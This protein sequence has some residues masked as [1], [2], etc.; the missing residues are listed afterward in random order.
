M[1]SFGSYAVGALA[2]VASLVVTWIGADR[3]RRRLLPGWI[4]APA[5][6]ATAIVSIS[7]LICLAEL[8][9]SFGLFEGVPFVAGLIVTGIAMRLAIA[10][11]SAERAEL[12]RP[13]AQ[14][15]NRWITIIGLALAAVAVAHF[16]IGTRIGYSGGMTGFDSTWYHGPYATHFVQSA[17]TWQIHFIAPQYLSWFYPQNSEILHGL[18]ILA[19][20]RDLI[21]PGLNLVWFAGCLGAAWCIGRP[22]GVAPISLAGVAVALD[23][24]VLADQAG[25]ARN[26]IVAIFFL[27]AA[28]AIAINAW[29]ARAGRKPV[30]GQEPAAGKPEADG[31][32]DRA[33]PGRQPGLPSGALIVVGLAIGL[34]AGTKVNYLAPAGVFAIGIAVIALSGLRLRSF[35][36]VAL[37]AFATAGYWYLRNTAHSGSP[38]PWFHGLGP[39]TLPGPDQPI[40]GRQQAGVLKYVADPSVWWHWFRPGLSDALSWAW[41]LLAL[42][43]VA[44]IWLCWRRPAG[45][46][47][48]LL[49]VVVVATAGA[50]LVAPASAEGPPGSPVGFES[51]LRYLIPALAIALALLPAT[52][53]MS[54]DPR[55]LL[56]LTGAL[57]VAFPLVD[58]SGDGWSLSYL[59]GAILVGVLVAGGAFWLARLELDRFPRPAVAGVLAVCGI[60]ALLG[61]QMI[62]RSY[63][64]NR[65]AKPTFAAP[66]LNQA[67]RWARDISGAR[68][69]TSATRQYPLMGLDL[70]NRVDYIGVRRPGAGFVDAPNCRTWRRLIN[71]GGYEFVVASGDRV[72]PGRVT[73]PPQA[74][75]TDGDP[76]ARLILLRSPT[77]VYRITGPLSLRGCRAPA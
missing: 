2:L 9:G 66:G 19:F 69:A 58:A 77:A 76:H 13:D 38:L 64:E 57:V 54:R 60:A 23:S 10:V 59:P 15:P 74:A 20:G 39:I 17:S 11:P 29:Q 6:L 28:V 35:F 67:F 25:E 22:Y 26:D 30:G 42:L 49:A 61:G 32:P 73:F 75:W 53:W 52:P 24:G 43:M 47:L 40:G 7:V 37:P 45:P 41:P 50:W 27:I 3:L 48:R 12:I 68:I 18:G 72:D 63:L 8:L 21:S 31:K 14:Q 55:R 16:S 34:A 51:G 5:L 33:K 46:M 36:F 1:L 65:Y 4:G 71:R 44:S 70:S 56:A 62:Q